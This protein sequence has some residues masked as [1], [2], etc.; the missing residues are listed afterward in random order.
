MSA[1]RK[2]RRGR[3]LRTGESQRKDL[4]YQYRYTDIRGKRRTVY[5]SDLKELR[6][7]EAKIQN[8]I[9]NGIDYSG[10]EITVLE[11]VDRYISTKRGVRYSTELGYGV[12][13]SVLKKDDFASMIIRNVRMSDAKLWVIKLHD[14]GYKYCSISN[15]KNVV[16]PAFRMAVE[17]DIIVKNPFDFKLSSVIPNDSNVRVALTAEQQRSFLEFIKN[18]GYFAKH[19]DEF[20]VLLGTGMRI[21][22]F[23]GLTFS[24]IDFDLR[25]IRVDHQISRKKD[26]TFYVSGTK[27]K[28]GTR[29]IP[30]T[31]E[32]YQAL[33]NIIANRPKIK[34]EP[35]IDGYSGFILTNVHGR[36]RL[37]ADFDK[38]LDRCNTKYRKLF[39][40]HQLPRVTPHVFR[41]TF[42]TNMSNAGMDIK[43][44]QY[45]MGHSN[46]NV[47]LNVYAH[48]DYERVEEQMRSITTPFTT[49]FSA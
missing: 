25:K 15:I 18:D 44:L 40:E 8:D 4:I 35:L 33:R 42:C 49:P 21:S 29:F 13:R 19:Y 1:K 14:S 22:E 16:R 47:T 17:E 10:G 39:P 28:K 26:G 32:V 6:E 12:I 45:V 27:T 11:L 41:H 36:P 30:M 38:I 23:C 43:P 20:I 46:V 48:V 9:C 5:S 2:D 7:K 31:D 3:V 34:E 24:D 37:A